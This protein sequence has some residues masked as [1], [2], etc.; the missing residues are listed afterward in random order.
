[1]KFSK[2]AAGLALTIAAASANATIIQDGGVALQAQLDSYTQTGFFD[3]NDAQYNPDEQWSIAGGNNSAFATYLFD[4]AIDDNSVDHA[5]GLY[6]VNDKSNVLTLLNTAEN[7]CQADSGVFSLVCSTVAVSYLGDGHFWNRDSGELAKLG[8]ANKFGFFLTHTDANGSST[9]YS[10]SSLNV[11][12][13]DHM[14]AFRGDDELLID[15]DK[16][17]EYAPLGLGDFVLAWEDGN[18]FD[19]ADV[20]VNVESTLPVPEPM[21]LAI[22]GLG[23]AAFGLRRRQK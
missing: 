1:M 4:V 2:I 10:E 6:D 12:G 20:I 21:P 3:V 22:L 19:F 5:F 9:V 7:T 18:N 17:N 23:L 13:N 8:N 15:I 14:I 16:N 11:G